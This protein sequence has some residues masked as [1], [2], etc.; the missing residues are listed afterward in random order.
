M[1]TGLIAFV[2]FSLTAPS[3]AHGDR[4]EGAQC[5]NDCFWTESAET[6]VA[7]SAFQRIIH[8][9]AAAEEDRCIAFRKILTCVKECPVD[10]Y[11]IL[12][13]ETS[14][15][16]ESY[17]GGYVYEAT[18]EKFLADNTQ[19]QKAWMTEFAKCGEAGTTPAE[20]C[21]WANCVFGSALTTAKTG[22]SDD[23]VIVTVNTAKLN[24]ASSVESSGGD[25]PASCEWIFEPYTPELPYEPEPYEPV[26][27]QRN[28]YQRNP[29]QRN[30]YQRNPYQRN[31]YQ[32]NPYQ[33]NPY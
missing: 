5:V 17:C 28:P 33:R 13:R 18:K 8:R 26:P 9:S 31:S 16:W 19:M 1:K 6:N 23:V 10:K 21:T 20:T 11:A 32:R 7:R 25:L 3:P 12:A 24:I 2:L 15:I 29:Y 4:S 14:V 22:F 30:P 27:Y